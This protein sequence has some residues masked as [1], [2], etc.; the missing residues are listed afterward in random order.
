MK[1]TLILATISR[2][3]RLSIIHVVIEEQI[4]LLMLSLDGTH[5]L[6]KHFIALTALTEITLRGESTIGT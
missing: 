2:V 4:F 1:I 5:F 6:A 3:P